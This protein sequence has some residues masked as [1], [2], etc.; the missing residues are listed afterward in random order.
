MK[1]LGWNNSGSRA[2]T[3][4]ISGCY[5]F[6]AVL[7]DSFST[8]QPIHL[9]VGSHDVLVRM[10]HRDFLLVNEDARRCRFSRDP[11]ELTHR[12]DADGDD[13]RIRRSAG[14]LVPGRLKERIGSI[15]DLPPMPEVARRLL[16]LRNRPDSTA[17]DLAEIVELDPALAAQVIRWAR[18]PFYGYRG[19]VESIQDAIIRVLGYEMVQNL[20]LG[21]AVG[22]SLRI[23][24]DGP[25]GRHAFW[26]HSVY[27]AALVSGLVRAMNTEH[28]PGPGMAYLAALLHNFGH[29]LLGQT[30]PTEFFLVNRFVAGN[31]HLSAGQVERWVLGVD[32]TQIGSWLMHSWNMPEPVIVAVRRH[33]DQEYSG[34]HA[35]FSRLVLVA[36]RLLR[37]LRMGDESLDT[38]PRGILESLGLTEEIAIAA[39]EDLMDRGDGLNMLSRQLAQGNVG[40]ATGQH[41][42]VAHR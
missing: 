15:R 19:E 29:L 39:L 3:P 22:R 18:S 26:R 33:H 13:E 32:H 24:P 21:L 30:F 25:L 40:D 34:E 16:A 20:A 10:S 28:R 12:P 38:L 7:D 8:D 2:A 11:A 37:R 41:R 6:P 27:C 36:N 14:D 42:A 35:E 31:R 9:E 1:S 5:P 4:P 17:E 23:P